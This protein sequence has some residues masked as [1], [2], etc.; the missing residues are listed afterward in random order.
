VKAAGKSA[1]EAAVQRI[2]PAAAHYRTGGGAGANYCTLLYPTTT[3]V[4][5]RVSSTVILQCND[6]M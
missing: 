3:G 4:A 6:I 5:G 2:P 1:P